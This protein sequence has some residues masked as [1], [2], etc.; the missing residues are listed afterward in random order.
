MERGEFNLLPFVCAM[1]LKYF[2][3]H[4][5]HHYLLHYA[6]YK[7]QLPAQIGFNAAAIIILKI[8]LYKIV[9]FFRKGFPHN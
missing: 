6:V 2:F 7:L 4:Q 9:R 3:R 8:F 1:M 5:Q